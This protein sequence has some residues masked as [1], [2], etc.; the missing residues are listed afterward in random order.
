MAPGCS[1]ARARGRSDESGATAEDAQAPRP[2]TLRRQRA[3][4]GDAQAPGREDE[5]GATAEDA[6]APGPRTLTPED[7]EREGARVEG[8]SGAPSAAIPGWFPCARRSAGR[9]ACGPQSTA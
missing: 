8:P 7:P 3:T 6:Q 2:R 5:S 1:G 4:T 9:E